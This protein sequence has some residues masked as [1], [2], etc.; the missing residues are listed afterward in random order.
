MP[1]SSPGSVTKRIARRRRRRASTRRV[2]SS[3]SSTRSTSY[4]AAGREVQRPSPSA[5]SSSSRPVISCPPDCHTNHTRHMSHIC[6]KRASLPG[7]LPFM[8]PQPGVR[9]L[10]P[11]SPIGHAPAGGH[12]GDPV[13]AS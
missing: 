11:G 8:T 6:H 12:A 3:S 13:P 7:P 1:R 2:S 9:L 10:T 4:P 5:I